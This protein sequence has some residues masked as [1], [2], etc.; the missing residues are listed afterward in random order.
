[1]NIRLLIFC[2]ALLVG[3]PADGRGQS[4]Y[5]AVVGVANDSS[6]AAVPGA[7]RHAHRSADDVRADRHQRPAPARS[8]SRT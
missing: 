7:T 2:S 6:G 8:S 1:M 3:L 5:G 4:T